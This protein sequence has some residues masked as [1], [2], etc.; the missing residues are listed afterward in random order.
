MK[1][2]T[3]VFISH[4]TKDK[5]VADA[6][7]A[8][9][10]KRGIQCWIAPRNMVPGEEYENQILSAIDATR[11]LVLIS[12]RNANSSRHVQREVAY[13]C[14]SKTPKEVVPFKIEDFEY[15]PNLKYYLESVQWLDAMPDYREK[16]KDLLEHVS[17]LLL[18]R[19]GQESEPDGAIKSCLAVSPAF[20][21]L[22]ARN[23]NFVGREDALRHLRELCDAGRIPVIHAAGGTGKSELVYE[24]AYRNADFYT[25]GCFHVPMEH[26]SEWES[27]FAA[28]L[29][30]RT[31]SGQDAA[32]WLLRNIRKEE[33]GEEKERKWREKIN[34]SILELAILMLREA[35]QN[36]VLMILDNMEDLAFLGDD[37]LNR[38]FPGGRP[39]QLHIVATSRQINVGFAEDEQVALFPLDNLSEADAMEILSR[40][41]LPKGMRE[42]NAA[43]K[44]VRALECH[45]WSVELAASEV[46]MNWRRGM[47]YE[48]KLCALQKSGIGSSFG[49]KSFRKTEKDALSLL[50]PTLDN[51][52]AN[53]D[54]ADRY[55]ELANVIAIFPAEGVEVHVLRWLCRTVLGWVADEDES[56]VDP[57]NFAIGV[58]RDYSIL[59]SSEDMQRV[60]MH[61]FTRAGLQQAMGED[62]MSLVD[63]V[64]NGL[65]EYMGYTK[66][67][68]TALAGASPLFSFCPLNCMDVVTAMT[69]AP[70]ATIRVIGEKALQSMTGDEISMIL[71]AHPDLRDKFDLTRLSAS[72]WCGLLSVRPEFL[73]EYPRNLKPSSTDLY[74]LLQAQPQMFD[75]FDVSIFDHDDWRRLLVANVGLDNRIDKGGFDA[76]D[77]QALLEERPEFAVCCP[78]EKLN[79]RHLRNL[80]QVRPELAREDLVAKLDDHEFAAVVR[81]QPQ[82]ASLRAGVKIESIPRALMNM[83]LKYPDR[84][85]EFDRSY[86][87][88]DELERVVCEHAELVDDFALSHLRPASWVKLISKFPQFTDRCD[89]SMLGLDDWLEL[90]STRPELA[91]G[92]NL[93]MLM[94]AY[95]ERYSDSYGLWKLF[96]DIP[97]LRDHCDFS[98]L[99]DDDKISFISCF[100][101]DVR[102]DDLQEFKGSNLAKLLERLPQ[103]AHSCDLSSLIEGEWAR[104]VLVQPQFRRI[105]PY[106]PHDLRYYEE[107]LLGM[108]RDFKRYYDVIDDDNR[109]KIYQFADEHE[110]SPERVKEMLNQAEEQF[111]GRNENHTDNHLVQFDDKDSHGSPKYCEFGRVGSADEITQIISRA[112]GNDS[113][114]EAVPYG[115]RFPGAAATM[116]LALPTADYC[117]ADYCTHQVKAYHMHYSE[118]S[119]VCYLRD[120]NPELLE[121]C[122]RVDGKY[123]SKTERCTL[124][125]VAIPREM[126]V[127]VIPGSGSGYYHLTSCFKEP[128]QLD[129]DFVKGLVRCRNEESSFTPIREVRIG[130]L[131]NK[132]TIDAF[133]SEFADQIRKSELWL[134]DY[135]TLNEKLPLAMTL[136]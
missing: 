73:S 60:G 66:E 116:L 114:V 8:I 96:N 76:Y 54:D 39:E 41:C 48:K 20:S 133:A 25:G 80:F 59:R 30:E 110:I 15:C 109:S 106:F 32:D 77:W 50:K 35:S 128:G 103:Y 117:T 105:V 42:K 72:D 33:R 98:K 119:L 112:L 37:G 61:R 58:L 127:R 102:E 79:S 82:L 75:A 67:M 13:A 115:D 27:A 28:M 130:F 71:R 43:V 136:D 57:V 38:L 85:S 129:S 12:S 18:E 23:K 88:G 14:N 19:H 68:W 62:M 16:L 31:S 45:A 7:C 44:V 81:E 89:L 132:E 99:N 24:Y 53:E 107:Q 26:V 87:T 92:I 108:I 113:E 10:E 84:A 6:V 126:N 94:E 118:E 11:V 49:G 90:L 101:D 3:D 21:T 123:V 91:S 4:S 121:R 29:R 135:D 74:W 51:L 63:R 100:P 93:D 17:R 78:F 125:L 124:Y 2:Q 1:L 5:Q 122:D 52:C 40:K 70:E 46:A 134:F 131:A 69:A 95:Y 22:P 36:P 34:R 56:D 65:V 111:S 97:A 9:L 120:N 104:L 86:L 47:T 83:L 64:G 55:L